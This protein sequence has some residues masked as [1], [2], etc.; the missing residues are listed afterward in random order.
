MPELGSSH[1][2]SSLTPS[3]C[4]RCTRVQKGRDLRQ[5]SLKLRAESVCGLSDPAAR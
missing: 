4:A 1:P 2:Q 5:A 3:P